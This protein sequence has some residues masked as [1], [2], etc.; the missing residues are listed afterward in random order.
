MNQLTVP[1]TPLPPS[2]V[3]SPVNDG[4]KCDSPVEQLA[5]HGRKAVKLRL[6]PASS[7][8]SSASPVGVLG[9]RVL[10][11]EAGGSRGE[12]YVG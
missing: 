11:V 3:G 8:L 7:S 4:I 10:L 1:Y 2:K 5:P 12:K 6:R 9:E